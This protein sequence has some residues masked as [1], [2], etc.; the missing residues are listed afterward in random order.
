MQIGF[1]LW[2]EI[3]KNKANEELK[4]EFF[5]FFFICSCFIVIKV[6]NININNFLFLFSLKIQIKQ[7]NSKIGFVAII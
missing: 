7:N 1:K 3:L 6:S 4:K 2:Q 5:L